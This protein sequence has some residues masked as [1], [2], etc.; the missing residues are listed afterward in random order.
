M[1]VLILGFSILQ[2]NLVSSEI[3]VIK[4]NPSFCFSV[5]VGKRMFKRFSSCFP[6]RIFISTITGKREVRALSITLV[7]VYSLPTFA[8]AINETPSATGT[9]AESSVSSK[10]MYFWV[11][12]NTGIKIFHASWCP[13]DNSSRR[14]I[15]FG[16]L[17]ALTNSDGWNIVPVSFLNVVFPTRAALASCVEPR[18][19]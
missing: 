10:R 5:A 2:A 1:K 9:T 17:S 8:V 7:A 3:L 4:W 16:V 12:S 14:I 19:K 11:L 6:L 15:A 18:L 13:L